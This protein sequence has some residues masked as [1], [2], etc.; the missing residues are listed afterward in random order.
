MDENHAGRALARRFLV[1]V[2]PAA[3][4]GEGLALEEF[5]IV[6]IRLVHQHQQNLAANVNALVIVP[7]ILRSFDAVTDVNDIG[8][9]LRLG[10]LR[11]VVGHIF[12]ERLEIHGRALLRNQRKGGLRQGRDAHQRNLLHVSS[13]VARRFQAIFG[14]LC[15]HVFGGNVAAALAGSS[16]FQQI[17]GKKFHVPA[18]VLG[19]DRLHRHKRRTR[20]PH[21]HGFAPRLRRWHGRW[22]GSSPARPR[23]ETHGGQRARKKTSSQ[24]CCHR[25]VI[26]PTKWHIRL[27]T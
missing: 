15:R 1:L 19:I 18:N 3:V 4:V 10:L 5:R 6:R 2:G 25:S 27:G 17:V 14:E 22:I 12:V 13:A 21:R 20:Q 23:R 11:P 26:S 8:I 9:H 16:S 7:A 24:D